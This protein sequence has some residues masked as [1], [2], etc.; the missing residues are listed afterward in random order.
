MIKLAVLTA[1]AWEIPFFVAIFLPSR[2][3]EISYRL[4]MGSLVG[5]LLWMIAWAIYAGWWVNNHLCY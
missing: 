2:W 5:M 1:L 3:M 4:A